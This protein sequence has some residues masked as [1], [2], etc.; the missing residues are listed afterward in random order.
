MAGEYE[1]QYYIKEALY[2]FKKGL[3]PE[4]FLRPEDEE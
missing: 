4:A 3:R 1:F 2:R